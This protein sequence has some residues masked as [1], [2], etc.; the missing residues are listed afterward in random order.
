MG[1]SIYITFNPDQE[2][3]LKVFADAVNPKLVDA[4]LWS[5]TDGILVS[6]PHNPCTLAYA[7]TEHRCHIGTSCNNQITENLNI[8]FWLGR[9]LGV[10]TYWFDGDEE[11]EIPKGIFSDKLVPAEFRKL[12]DERTKSFLAIL[13]AHKDLL[14]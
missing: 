7:K 4:G 14:S 5:K 6:G 12:T 3:K 13:E 2:D 11:I 1:V 8:V 9:A 10:K